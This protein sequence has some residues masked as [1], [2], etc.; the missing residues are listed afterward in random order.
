M[1]SLH[2]KISIRRG[3]VLMIVLVLLAFI[4]IITSTLV[5]QMLHDR[6]D[7]RMELVRRQARQLSSDAIRNAETQ[8]RS[9]SGFSGETLTLGPNEQPFPGTFRLTTKYENDRFNAEVE[10]RDENE[11]LLYATDQ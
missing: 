10:Y 2:Q 7:A 9:N 4:G 3:A 5:P 8:R 6:Q 1:T 11:K